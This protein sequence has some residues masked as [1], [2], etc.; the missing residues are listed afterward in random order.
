M[1][2]LYLKYQASKLIELQV[3]SGV[4]KSA[5]KETVPRAGSRVTAEPRAASGKML[6][7]QVEVG[8]TWKG[9]KP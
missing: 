7:L 6:N 5:G 1:L 2:F 3:C 4:A 9:Q 8:L